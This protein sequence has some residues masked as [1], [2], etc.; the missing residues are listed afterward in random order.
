M[1][2]QKGGTTVQ[3]CSGHPIPLKVCCGEETGPSDIRPG[4]LVGLQRRAGVLLNSERAR[5][6]STF[7]SAD[8]DVIGVAGG[9]GDVER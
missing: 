7:P 3:R 9:H 6:S 5:A 4:G 8:A 2:S 1:W